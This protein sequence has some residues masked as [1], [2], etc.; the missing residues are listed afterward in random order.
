MKNFFILSLTVALLVTCYKYKKLEND[1]IEYK[2]IQEEANQERIITL[3]EVPSLEFEEFE[4][5]EDTIYMSG[6]INNNVC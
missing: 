4:P 3:E 2:E 6:E 5:G 1:F